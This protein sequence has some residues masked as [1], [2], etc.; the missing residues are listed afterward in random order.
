LTNEERKTQ[1]NLRE[2]PRERGRGK[3]VKI[4]YRKIQIKD[5]WQIWVERGEK[6]KKKN[7]K[8][9]RRREDEPARKVIKRRRIKRYM[10]KGQRKR[11][12]EKKHKGKCRYRKSTNGKVKWQKEK[13]KSYPGIITRVK[14]GI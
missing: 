6:L 2:V 4:G 3:R 9:G 10:D 1:K 14:L 5:E 7:R 13:R 12:P 8:K 11:K